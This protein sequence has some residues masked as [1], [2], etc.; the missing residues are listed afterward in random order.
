MR[1]FICAHCID[2]KMLVHAHCTRKDVCPFFSHSACGIHSRVHR[3]LGLVRLRL[4]AYHL[5]APVVV[6]FS[7]R[8]R[9]QWLVVSSQI[10][11]GR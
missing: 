6:P 10:D 4:H 5:R 7:A 8:Y 11:A 1:M 9:N 2:A 3:A